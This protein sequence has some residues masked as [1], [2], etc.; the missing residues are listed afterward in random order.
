MAKETKKSKLETPQGV[1]QL[2]SRAE[3]PT[4]VES[5]LRE[6]HRCLEFVVLPSQRPSS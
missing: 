6:A 1:E 3:S 2:P 4:R 5:A